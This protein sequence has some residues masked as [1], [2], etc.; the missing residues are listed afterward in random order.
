MLGAVIALGL[1]AWSIRR[2]EGF[3]S[4]PLMVIPKQ[5]PASEVAKALFANMQNEY[6]NYLLVACNDIEKLLG[7]VPDAPVDRT[8]LKCR[9]EIQKI[10]NSSAPA[11]E[12]LLRMFDALPPK[13]DIYEKIYPALINLTN[14]AYSRVS[15]FVDMARFKKEPVKVVNDY[16]HLSNTRKDLLEQI[17]FEKLRR[18]YQIAIARLEILQSQ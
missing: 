9:D 13:V 6:R 3:T 8:L 16:F 17:P 2:H 14:N 4:E 1:V 7:L 15:G 10:N 12:K 18:D 11:I 5:F